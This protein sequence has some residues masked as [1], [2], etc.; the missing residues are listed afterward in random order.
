MSFPIHKVYITENHSDGKATFRPDEAAPVQV[1]GPLMQQ[2]LIYST[3][4]PLSVHDNA[5]LEHNIA[6]SNISPITFFPPQDA[7]AACILDFAPGC[8]GMMHKTNSLDYIM[9]L[10]DELELELLGGERKI[11]K[12][13]EMVIQR[14]R[15]S[16]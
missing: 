14:D 1:I 5:D 10:E 4:T 12:K 11:I 3:P 2:T 6:T 7:T 16:R 15:E 13:G 9:I 8:E